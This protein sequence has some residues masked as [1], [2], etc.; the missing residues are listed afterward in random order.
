[1]KAAFKDGMENRIRRPRFLTGH[2]TL[3]FIMLPNSHLGKKHRSQVFCGD[4]DGAWP[5]L[6]GAGKEG[7]KVINC[8]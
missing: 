2:Q 3:H 8:A 5:S 6:A 1:M 7:K 4:S